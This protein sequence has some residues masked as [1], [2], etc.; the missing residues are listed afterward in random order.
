VFPFSI[1]SK[2]IAFLQKMDCA[3]A[4]ILPYGCT[5]GFVTVWKKN[6]S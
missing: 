4:E 1:L 5:G 2:R 6:I 3:I